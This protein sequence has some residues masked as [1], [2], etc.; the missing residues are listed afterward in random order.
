MNFLEVWQHV[1]NN[2]NVNHYAQPF[3]WKEI[4]HCFRFQKVNGIE[5]DGRPYVAFDNP[6][7][8]D[9]RLY[10]DLWT[11]LTYDDVDLMLSKGGWVHSSC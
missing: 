1:I 7:I 11:L 3:S 2:P 9:P 8:S 5:R 4:N 6:N 10:L